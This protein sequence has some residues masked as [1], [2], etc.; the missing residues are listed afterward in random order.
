MTNNHASTDVPPATVHHPGPLACP[1]CKEPARTVPP[2]DW[3]LARWA[4][5][6]AYSHHD[7]TALCPVPATHGSQ[8][9][10]PVPAQS[11]TA[12]TPDAPVTRRPGRA[13]AP[14]PAVVSGHRDALIVRPEGSR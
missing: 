7:G 14:V 6:P 12:G 5:R 13:N 8:P 9:A 1:E 4:P 3:P 2:R 11:G 10:E